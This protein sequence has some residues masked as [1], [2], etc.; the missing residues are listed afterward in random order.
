MYTLLQMVAHFQQLEN[1]RNLALSY[2]ALRL[3][4]N[5]AFDG[6][7]TNKNNGQTWIIK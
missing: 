7:N 2:T 5:E 3:L 4:E 1:K 6:D